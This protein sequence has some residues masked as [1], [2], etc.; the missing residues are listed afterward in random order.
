MSYFPLCGG[1]GK[2]QRRQRKM[3]R[4]DLTWQGKEARVMYEN[5]NGSYVK[6]EDV[7]QMLFSML[8]KNDPTREDV[9]YR[10]DNSGE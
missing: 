6:Y 9:E 2:N 8:R 5:E 3:K 4:Y 10:I 1:S 7:V